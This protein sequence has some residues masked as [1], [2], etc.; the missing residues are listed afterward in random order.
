MNWPGE[1]GKYRIQY[2]QS[3][4]G[5]ATVIGQQVQDERGL[6]TVRRYNPDMKLAPY[7]EVTETKPN[8]GCCGI[9]NK[10]LC[11]YCWCV[12]SCV[13]KGM[14]ESIDYACDGNMSI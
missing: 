12:H 2:T 11:C 5:E 9:Q 13:N 4:C 8:F 3:A 14:D 1:I 10:C 6:I 7:G